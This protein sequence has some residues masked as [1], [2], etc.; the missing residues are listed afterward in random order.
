MLELIDGR[1]RTGNGHVNYRKIKRYRS[2]ML[3]VLFFFF[4][5]GSCCSNLVS[6][7]RFEVRFEVFTVGKVSFVV[8]RLVALCVHVA[9]YQRFSGSCCLHLQGFHWKVD[10]Y[11]AGQ[12]ESM[13][14]WNPKIHYRIRVSPLFDP[15]LSWFIAVLTFT[16]SF[17]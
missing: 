4:F 17:R 16:Q 3:L 15:V 12:K 11:S 6:S 2:V 5:C 10:N 7:V 8:L 13:L 1:W 9:G 14:S